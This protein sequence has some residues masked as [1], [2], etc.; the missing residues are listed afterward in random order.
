M[1]KAVLSRANT[2]YVIYVWLTL[3]FMALAPGSYMSRCI[4]QHSFANIF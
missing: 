3:L 1:L 2:V 4:I